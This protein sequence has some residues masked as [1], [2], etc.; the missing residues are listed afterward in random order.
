MGSEHR[1]TPSIFPM[2]PLVVP[3]MLETVTFHYLSR[4]LEPFQ[5]PLACH[6]LK[7]GAIQCVNV[8]ECATFS[9]LDLLVCV[10]I[11]YL[12]LIS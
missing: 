11:L 10:Y 9:A 12:I 3:R 6:V 1:L 8:S 7:Q 2:V 5:Q 4:V